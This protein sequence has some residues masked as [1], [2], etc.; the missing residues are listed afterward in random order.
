[1]LTL[2]QRKNRVILNIDK[3]KTKAETLGFNNTIVTV[4]EDLPFLEQM[5]IIRCT[6]VLL[7]V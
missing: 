3:L 2:L 4:F 1:M 7:G 5:Q 6:R